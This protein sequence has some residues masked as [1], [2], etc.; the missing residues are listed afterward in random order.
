M[1]QNIEL[2]TSTHAQKKH[3]VSKIDG[4]LLETSG[5]TVIITDIKLL[6]HVTA[7]QIL[8]FIE[9]SF[10]MTKLQLYL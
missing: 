10:L 1:M 9:I 6:L 2:K 5:Y 7:T 3:L 4:S 8:M